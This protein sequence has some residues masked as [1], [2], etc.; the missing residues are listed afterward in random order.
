MQWL[1]AELLWKTLRKQ[2]EWH[3]SNHKNTFLWFL[4]LPGRNCWRLRICC[5]QKKTTKISRYPLV[6]KNSQQ[7]NFP[8]PFRVKEKCEKELRLGMNHPRCTTI[9]LLLWLPWHLSPYKGWNCWKKIQ[10]V[11]RMP[12]RGVCKRLACTDNTQQ[13]SVRHNRQKPG[14]IK[15]I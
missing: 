8:W 13:K 9:Y 15:Q 2:P 3:Y 1:R 10:H 11:S 4:L 7:K 12:K 6:G 5:F 14:E